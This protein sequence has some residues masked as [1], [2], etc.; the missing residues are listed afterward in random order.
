[1]WVYVEYFIL[2]FASEGSRGVVLFGSTPTVCLALRWILYPRT[3][4]T[5]QRSMMADACDASKLEFY[6]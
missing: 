4:A 6:S 2:P 1:M 5:A 3:A